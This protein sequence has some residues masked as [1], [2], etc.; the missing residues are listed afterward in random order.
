MRRDEWERELADLYVELGMART[1]LLA[2]QK[3]S[4]TEDIQRATDLIKLVSHEISELRCKPWWSQSS[5]GHVDLTR[6]P[7]LN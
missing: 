3:D 2:A 4:R 1:F 5:G 7:A 6:N